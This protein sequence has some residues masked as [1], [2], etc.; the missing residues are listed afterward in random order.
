MDGVARA[1][2][3]DDCLR[4]LE[5]D[6]VERNRVDVVQDVV[7]IADRQALP[8]QNASDLGPEDAR[9]HEAIVGLA[10]RP[11]E[12][13]GSGHRMAQHDAYRDRAVEVVEFD[14]LPALEGQEST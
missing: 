14:V 6:V 12:P 7:S 10:G 13:S 3:R 5:H 4:F 1:D 11:I 9:G 2:V 8:P